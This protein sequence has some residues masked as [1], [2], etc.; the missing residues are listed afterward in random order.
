MGVG[1][2]TG[3][4]A[5]VHEMWRR[6]QFEAADTLLAARLADDPDDGRLWELRGLTRH[7]MGQPVEALRALET[8]T[9]LVPLG[10]L[11]QYVLAECYQHAGQQSLARE[12]LIYLATETQCCTAIL[13]RL[14]AQLGKIGELRLALDVCRDASQREPDRDE[15]L[16]AMAYYMR[17]LQYPTSMIV[18]L[19]HRAVQLAPESTVYRVALANLYCQME[20]WDQAYRAARQLEP[21]QVRCAKCVRQMLAVFRSQGDERR[22]RAWESRLGELVEAGD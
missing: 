20:C 21:D 15:P 16:Y 12:I 9:S 14:A 6:R 22:C 2:E 19:V 18:S 8:A 4:A 7:K 17:K 1:G 3:V 5:R 13:P 10:A 11:A